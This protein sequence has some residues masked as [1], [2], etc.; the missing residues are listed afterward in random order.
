MPTG[1]IRKKEGI[2]QATKGTRFHEEYTTKS[3]KFWGGSVMVWGAIKE[4][5]TKIFIRCPDRLN[6]KVCMGVLNKEL[7]PIYGHKDIF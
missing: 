1:I 4:D 2:R 3:I 6:S 5:G 7:L